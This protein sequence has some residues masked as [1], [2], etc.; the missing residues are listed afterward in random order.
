MLGQAVGAYTDATHGMTL[1]AV[2]MAY[3][4]HIL[5]YG[6][7]KFKRYAVNVWGVN[8]EGKSDKEVAEEG[9]RAMEKWMNKLGLVMNLTKLG[10]TPDLIDGI[11]DATR[12]K[13]G[14]YKAPTREEVVE[15]LKNSL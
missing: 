13:S 1:S 7:S 15:I 3:Y 5:P 12:T 9:L 6:L 8:A 10:V 4:K 2:T 14:G 11:A